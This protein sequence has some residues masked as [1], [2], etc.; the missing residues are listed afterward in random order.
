MSEVADKIQQ[1]ALALPESMGTLILRKILACKLLSATFALNISEWCKAAGVDRD[2]WYRYHAKP[3]FGGHC[4]EAAKLSL[5]PRVPEI[6][7]AF[8]N[9]AIKGGQDG[10]G[11]TT[12]QLALMRQA[13]IID[14]DTKVDNALTV[15]IIER[16]AKIER[17][18]QRL[19]LTTTP[20]P[21]RI[22]SNV[23]SVDSAHA[24]DAEVVE[25]EAV[26]VD[27]VDDD[28]EDHHE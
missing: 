1:V 28:V 19:G 20:T 23:D 17:G 6:W 21:K 12:A 7:A 8:V 10:M 16:N 3:D 9:K 2:S 15:T 14:K 25:V 11:D 22:A 13:T 27:V 4:I 5:G 26:V 18:M 24:D